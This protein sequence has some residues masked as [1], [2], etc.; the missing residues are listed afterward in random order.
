MPSATQL[1]RIRAL[2]GLPLVPA[3]LALLAGPLSARSQESGN[4]GPGDQ[5]PGDHDGGDQVGSSFAHAAEELRGELGSALEELDRLRDE[6]A[7]EKIP[8]QQELSRAE[9]ELSA[10]RAEFQQAQ[11]LLDSRTVDLATL[12]DDLKA[13]ADTESYLSGLLADYLRNFESRLHIAELGRY[14]DVLGAAKRAPESA[15][16]SRDEVNRAQVAL[17][18]AS[19]DRLEDA[20]GGTRFEGTALDSDRLERQ[21]TFLLVGPSALFR[22]A[23][24]QEIGTAEQRLGSLEPAVI[25]FL[26]PEDAAA[27]DH[28]VATGA[29]SFPFDPTLGNAHKIEATEET[30]LEHIEKGGPVMVPIFVLAA[31]SLLVAITKWL[32]LA[33]LRM[34][35]RKRVTAV[36][37]AVERQ[38]VE[39]ARERVKQIRGPTGKM[40]TAGVEHMR[41][42]RELVEEVMFERVLTT[43]LKLQSFLP[44]ISVSAA[45][46]PLLGLLGTVTGIIHTFKMIT[47]YGSGDVKALSGGISEA[48]IT[49]EYGLI[50]A[51]PSLLL[52]AYLSRKARG[53]TDRMEKTAV[54]FANMV[55]KTH[56][57][58]PEPPRTRDLAPVSG[59]SPDPDLVRAQVNQILGEILGPLVDEQNQFDGEPIAGARPRGR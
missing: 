41:E 3:L 35:S 19:L 57:L 2:S 9:G 38:D 40:L 5:G 12:H 23:D 39:S 32:S 25:A 37:E 17:I 54:A 36:L 49:T 7:R 43:R 26:R 33:F 46:A 53:I 20:L 44:F 14:A 8:L 31:L 59:G 51:I 50:V 15:D 1:P 11:R 18:S 58:V 10:V 48:L 30:L 13:Y 6:M 34:P 22:S 55:G 27:A 24:G 52:H 47:V 45:S 16:L 42:P 21:G 56:E 28:L 4:Q 29:G